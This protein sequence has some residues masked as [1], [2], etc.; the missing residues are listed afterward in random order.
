[1]KLSDFRAWY[2]FF[3]PLRFVRHTWFP[4]DKIRGLRGSRSLYSIYTVYV[5]YVVYVVCVV[6][7]VSVVRKYLEIVAAVLFLFGSFFDTR[8]H[9]RT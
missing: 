9:E 2:L 3:L 6:S 7:V 8:S 1:M 5:V 4:P